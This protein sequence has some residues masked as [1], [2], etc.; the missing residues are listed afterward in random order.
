MSHPRNVRQ[1]IETLSG[2]DERANILE[3]C[4]R[5][6][7]TR[8][9]E[10][11][12]ALSSLGL[13][14]TQALQRTPPNW[15]PRGDATK[16]SF[17]A[18]VLV[19]AYRFTPDCKSPE[20]SS[21]SLVHVLLRAR[22]SLAEVRRVVASN[23]YLPP[24]VT[25]QAVTSATARLTRQSVLSTFIAGMPDTGRGPLSHTG[26]ELGRL[27]DTAFGKQL[28]LRVTGTMRATR[29]SG[30][31]TSADL[32]RGALALGSDQRVSDWLRSTGLNEIDWIRDLPAPEPLSGQALGDYELTVPALR[33]LATT[34]KIAESSAQAPNTDRV[35]LATLITEGSFLE[36]HLRQILGPS[37]NLPLLYIRSA[38]PGGL[39]REEALALV[40]AGDTL[41]EEG[42]Q[43]LVGDVSRDRMSNLQLEAST[44]TPGYEA[45]RRLDNWGRL[46]G[47]PADEHDIPGPL[48]QG[49]TTGALD[50]FGKWFL[51]EVPGQQFNPESFAMAILRESRSRDS[52]GSAGDVSKL[53][54]NLFTGDITGR[55]AARKV[56]ARTQA[57]ATG[58]ALLGLVDD[59]IAV[60][61][62]ARAQADDPQGVLELV[63]HDTQLRHLRPAHNFKPARTTVSLAI[64]GNFGSWAFAVVS[65]SLNHAW[66]S[67][68]DENALWDAWSQMRGASAVGSAELADAALDFARLLGLDR[69]QRAFDEA[70]VNLYVVPPFDSIFLDMAVRAVAR[71]R[72]VA[73]R[74]LGG[75]NATWQGSLRNLA[76]TNGHRIF[77]EDPTR[78][79]NAARQE[80]ACLA[81][82]TGGD[83]I[84]GE[85]ASRARV[86]RALD[87]SRGIPQLL[88][89]AGHGVSGLTDTQDRLV[90]GVVVAEHEVITADM[91]REAGLPRVIIASACDL[92]CLPPLPD[93][94][95][96]HASLIGAGAGYSVAACLPVPDAGALTFS[97]ALHLMWKRVDNLELAV[98]KT[99]ALGTQPEALVALLHESPDQNAYTYAAEWVANCRDRDL[100]R[101]FTSFSLA[102]A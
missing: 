36:A 44:M 24:L 51:A 31:A 75:T 23:N 96:W 64:G 18:K 72:S 7:R 85:G 98:A 2:D 5:L 87:A 88:H 33:L 29:R 84:S 83:V 22:S 10:F 66:T 77:V 68:L 19:D 101:V 65:P 61:Y 41:C 86:L 54:M 13:D 37:I 102:T 50:A 30:P 81:R 76:R 69:V 89:F 1:F 56:L 63:R 59:K 6:E 11:S 80:G 91:I 70:H 4:G 20:A 52:T 79:L 47:E 48:E 12:R 60:D 97:L 71:P 100:E 21:A 78:T 93:A 40:R 90:S 92:A 17:P 99:I 58:L 39:T 57:S 95:G 43:P 55:N 38:R 3:A 35:I 74:I 25:I 82:V 32:V 45:M 46:W 49:F 14:I 9:S 26:R 34:Q 42:P 28:G 53:M 94:R 73:Y 67:T 16:E 62:V 8:S 15:H 27:A